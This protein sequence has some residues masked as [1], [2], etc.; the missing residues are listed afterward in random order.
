[1]RKQIISL[2]LASI[3]GTLVVYA[4]M[5][6]ESYIHQ[7]NDPEYAEMLNYVSEYAIPDLGLILLFF[8]VV[9]PFQ[10]LFILPTQRFLVKK[11]FSSR[12]IFLLVFGFST[13]IYATIFTVAFSSPYLGIRDIYQTFGWGLVIFGSYFLINLSVQHLFLKIKLN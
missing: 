7:L 4:I 5:E 12:N 3:F 10:F 13:T 6:L 1:M 9:L 2:S 8:I 11:K